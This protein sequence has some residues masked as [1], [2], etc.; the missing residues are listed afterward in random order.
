MMRQYST[1]YING[2]GRALAFANVKGFI[3]PDQVAS[4]MLELSGVLTREEQAAEQQAVLLDLGSFGRVQ[5]PV[6]SAMGDSAK[7]AVVSLM[8]GLAEMDALLGLVA[9]KCECDKCV[10]V[11]KVA[12]NVH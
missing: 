7:G 6:A 3:T 1:D 5:I 2:I 8:E 12:A 9:Q 10:A 11:R 4:L